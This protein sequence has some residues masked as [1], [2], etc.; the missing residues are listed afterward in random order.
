MATGIIR[1]QVSAPV[2]GTATYTKVEISR[3]PDNAGVPGAWSVIQAALTL[4]TSGEYTEYVDLTAT[5]GMWYRHR[6]Y[7][8][9][10]A[11]SDYSTA[12]QTNDFL[13]KQW[14]NSDLSFSL[15]LTDAQL[16]RWMA[17]SMLDLWT[18]GIW[19]DDRATVVPADAVGNGIADEWY[20]IPEVLHEVYA[21]EKINATTGRALSPQV[22]LYSQEWQQ[23]NRSV[24]LVGQPTGYNYVLYAKRRFRYPGELTESYFMLFYWMVR[25][26]YIEY[27]KSLREETR[28]YIV[29]DRTS[30]VSAADLSRMLAEAKKEVAER[31]QVLTEPN[32]GQPAAFGP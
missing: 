17:E 16:E 29:F 1:Y 14:L 7:D 21:V 15:S 5:I 26:K 23:R 25:V 3:A 27:Q 9:V 20:P 22:Y 18:S 31:L 30:D 2:D 32:P 8:N 4:S 28:R 24:R 13:V 11:Y 19:V 10:S 12:I 6:F